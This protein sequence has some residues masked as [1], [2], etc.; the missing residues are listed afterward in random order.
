[1]ILNLVFVYKKK[2]YIPILLFVVLSIWN[3]KPDKP[4]LNVPT[5]QSEWEYNPTPFTLNYPQHFPPIS[6]PI[7]NPLTV[8]GV[9]LGRKLFYDPILSGDGTQA[10][11]DCHKQANAFTDP[12][13]FSTGIDGLQGN[14]NAM[15]IINLAWA[16]HSLFWDG[17]STSLEHQALGPVVNPIEMHNTWKNAS[18]KLKLHPQYPKLFYEAFGTANIDSNLV[19]KA[20][21][22]FERTLISGNSRFDRWIKQEIIPTALELQGFNLFITDRNVNAGIS[23]ADCFHCHPHSNGMFTDFLLHNNGLDSEPFADK[24]LGEITGNPS[25]FGKFRTPTLRNW[26]FSAPYMHDSRFQTID[27]VIDFYSSGLKHSST[28]DPLMKNI[29]DNG[30]QLSP[31]EKQALKAFLMMLNDTSFVTN[32]IFSKPD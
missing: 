13:P 12:A 17:R 23:G 5:P 7:D 2:R 24:G 26:A 10:C 19:V 14:R 1:M 3:C 21:A 8:Q 18:N 16:P 11:A 9:E 29:N 32:P 6:F 28:I 15:T 22:Q 30:V 31:Q 25:D 20:I 27:E 4:K